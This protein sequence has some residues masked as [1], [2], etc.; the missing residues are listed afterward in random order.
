MFVCHYVFCQSTVST[1][2]FANFTR[3]FNL[4]ICRPSIFSAFLMLFTIFSKYWSLSLCVVDASL[5]VVD[6]SL[7][8]YPS[9]SRNMSYLHKSNRH[10]LKQ[11]ISYSIFRPDYIQSGGRQSHRKILLI[12]LSYNSCTWTWESHAHG[13]QYFC[14]LAIYFTHKL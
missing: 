1:S 12:D 11:Y 10:P 13:K 2:T 5:C 14:F 8:P 9:I 7:S 4:T 6:A 3:Y